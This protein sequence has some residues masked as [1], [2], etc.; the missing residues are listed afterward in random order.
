M[1]DRCEGN[2]KVI[3]TVMPGVYQISLCNCQNAV[4]VKQEAAERRE[5]LKRKID[6]TF[7]RLMGGM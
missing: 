3:E 7:E 2:G 6:E 5:R 1:C 4:R